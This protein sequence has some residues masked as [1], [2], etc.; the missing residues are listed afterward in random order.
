MEYT[1]REIFEEFG[2]KYL[3]KYK[4]SYEQKKVLNRIL[5]CRTERLGTRI[6][7]CDECGMKVFT[8]NSCKDRHCPS[9]LSY[10]KE[11]WSEHNCS[12]FGVAL[13]Y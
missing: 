2:G 12:M 6:Y 13:F 3:K 4:P 9:C 10:K 1:I 7:Q 8:Y 5:D 11:V